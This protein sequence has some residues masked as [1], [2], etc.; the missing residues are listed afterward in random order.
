[1]PGIFF[2]LCRRL[3]VGGDVLPVVAVFGQEGDVFAVSALVL[4]SG[5]DKVIETFVRAGG[6]G[7]GCL[8][9][10]FQL[11]AEFLHGVLSA[12]K[13]GLGAGCHGVRVGGIGGGSRA[14]EVCRDHAG[15][16]CQSTTSGTNRQR[17]NPFYEPYIMAKPSKNKVIH[18]V[19][20][21]RQKGSGV[22]FCGIPVFRFI[23]RKDRVPQSLQFRVLWQ[24]FLHRTEHLRQP[25]GKQ[26]QTL[27]RRVS[28]RPISRI[29]QHETPDPLH[30]FPNFS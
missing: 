4:R 3:P 6:I 25:K 7:A 5:F 29:L 2:F 22:S 9:G 17:K 11:G 21:V 19:K 15:D 16:E 30:Y 8:L 13:L 12:F 20:E 26:M 14:I 24:L 23:G 1:M 18:R 27:L 10:G 28:N